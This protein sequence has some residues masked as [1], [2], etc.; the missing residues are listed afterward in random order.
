MMNDIYWFCG[1]ACSGKSTFSER[2]RRERHLVIY[3]R[4]DHQRDHLQKA[5][6]NTHPTMYDSWKNR[7]N[8]SEL[9]HKSPVDIFE[10]A[11][12][13]HGEAIDFV[14]SDLESMIAQQG[15]IAEGVGFYPTF[16]SEIS[17]SHRVVYFLPD[18]HLIHDTWV[19]RYR[20]SMWLDNFDNAEHIVQNFIDFT[21][22]E[23]EYIKHELEN[24]HFPSIRT[25][26]T[27]RK[28]D[29]MNKIYEIIDV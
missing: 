21:I 3:H 26:L 9:Y 17:T 25:S 2:L 28:D 19:Q 4:D 6:K 27:I 10:H 7:N 11:K 8:W 20:N 24:Y 1:P 14:V 5:E 29:I 23:R 13:E 12:K 16:M 18:D 15:I 22:L